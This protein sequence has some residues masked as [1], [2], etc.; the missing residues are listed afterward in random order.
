M[1]KIFFFIFAAGFCW[2]ILCLCEFAY[3]ADNQC[4]ANE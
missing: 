4:T 1:P 3:D 2:K